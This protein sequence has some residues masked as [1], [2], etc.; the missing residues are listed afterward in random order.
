MKHRPVLTACW[1]GALQVEMNESAPGLSGH[2]VTSGL[3]AT[4]RSLALNAAAFPS[5]S[6]SFR[7]S[8]DRKSLIILDCIIKSVGESRLLDMRWTSLNPLPP[9]IRSVRTCLVVL[10]Q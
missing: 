9:P 6:S 7:S 2:V 5:L 1:L 8:V 4:G 10:Q 3:Y